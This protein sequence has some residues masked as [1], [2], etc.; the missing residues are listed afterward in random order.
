MVEVLRTLQARADMALASNPTSEH[1]RTF[2]E[3]EKAGWNAAAYILEDYLGRADAAQ[4]PENDQVEARR[5]GA[6]ASR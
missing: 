4:S 5:N 2:A 3:G 1:D 6:P